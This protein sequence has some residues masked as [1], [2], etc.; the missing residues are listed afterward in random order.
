MRNTIKRLEIR[1][2]RG[3][4]A[5]DIDAGDIN[6]FAG[7]N[8]QG[9]T[10]ILDAIAAAM[11]GKVPPDAVHHD[12]KAA[13]IRVELSDG[14]EVRRRV[15]ASGK[16]TVTVK[17]D[18]AKLQSPQA[19]LDALFAPE[20][21]DPIAFIEAK[22]RQKRLLEAL[23]VTTDPKEVLAYLESVGLGKG[24]VK[25]LRTEST[26]AFEVFA[27]VAKML[28]EDRKAE[29]RLVKEL[30]AW[31]KT[32]RESLGEAE[33]PAE[34]ID[35]LQAERAEVSGLLGDARGL[36]KQFTGAESAV[37]E[38][39]RDLGRRLEAIKTAEREVQAAEQQLKNAKARLSDAKTAHEDQQSRLGSAQ[40][41]VATLKKDYPDIDATIASLTE[42]DSAMGEKLLKLQGKRGA[43]QESL[44]QIGK[45]EA[46]ETELEEKQARAKALDAGV[47]L[48]QKQAPAEALAKTKMP[49]AGLEYKDGKFYVNGTHIDQLSGAETLDIAARFTI[50]KVRQ[51]GLHVLCVD[52]LEKLKSQW[53]DGFF[54]LMR[55]AGIQ[56]WAAEVDHGQG[57]PDGEGVLYVVM[58]GGEPTEVKT[59]V[60]EAEEETQQ[61]G[62]NF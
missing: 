13:E 43:Y 27:A 11:Q 14:T 6:L 34:E 37:V 22:D 23:P 49:V 56:L 9:K 7:D 57:A 12:A 60:A 1:D 48:F 32:E 15:P 28:A 44:K 2:F 41:D 47:K 33:D 19:V 21:F 59:T 50:E 46:K 24:D 20:G 8:A 17:R 52:G 55:D 53:R 35:R 16:A 29:N 58:S 54:N 38:A 45:V 3:I 30:A 39:E 40:T 31:I 10:G 5:I 18:R 61:S 36:V 26:H 42:S 51:K 4:K 25:G 62:L